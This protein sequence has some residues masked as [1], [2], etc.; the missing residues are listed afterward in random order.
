MSDNTDFDVGNYGIEELIAI[1]DALDEVPLSKADIIDITQRYIDKY[2]D[3]PKFKKF[4]FDV[5]KKLLAE[6][7]KGINESIFGP[8]Q[9]ELALTEKLVGD[10]YKLTDE[11]LDEDKNVKVELEFPS[12]ISKPA[13]FIQG[14]L[15]PTYIDKEIRIVNFDSKDRTILDP[16]PT[17][18]FDSDGNPILDSLNSNARLD[19]ATNYTATI[20][21]INNVVELCLNDVQVP[22]AWYVFNSSYGTNYFV[23]NQDA[24]PCMIEEG[25]YTNGIDLIDT[26][27]GE[28]NAD[29][30]RNLLFKYHSRQNKVS[31]TNQS[32]Q[33]V[34]VKW[35]SPI[36]ELALCVEGG[37]VGQKLDYN[38]GW[39]LGFRSPEYNIPPNGRIV[40][41]GGLDLHGPRYLILA[42]DDFCNNK[43]NQSLISNKSN[44]QNFKLPDYYNKYTMD[45]GCEVPVF[46]TRRSGCRA[47]TANADLSSNLTQSQR[48]TVDQLKLAMNG[49]SAD[50]YD[51]PTTSDL[52]YRFPVARNVLVP[53][54]GATYAT[55]LSLDV[56]RIYYGP[57]N[58]SKFRIRLL[59]DRGLLLNL[60]NN[61]W[62]FSV[63][64]TVLKSYGAK[65]NAD[66]LKSQS[67]MTYS[68]VK[69]A[70]DDRILT[71]DER[72][73]RQK[74]LGF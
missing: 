74:K 28:V 42:L 7:A 56:K 3:N 4:F 30:S 38:L 13:S 48:Y 59:D 22:H 39:L 27:N 9:T 71:E 58:L 25:N 50:R 69:A 18:C 46:N 63:K 55:N 1:M 5:R 72:L 11:L 16:V 64:M 47:V 73:E 10:R 26:I 62:S 34:T 44:K 61:D 57:V 54:G 23:T 32:S 41:E 8:Q 66:M 52:L 12:I 65:T 60:N 15:N 17:N 49:K 19:S 14:R 36:A 68:A 45:F 6:K 40:S 67:K 24:K 43:P 35:Y 70:L 51:P 31:V 21:P 2:G 37:A 20:G 29:V 33:V 53:N